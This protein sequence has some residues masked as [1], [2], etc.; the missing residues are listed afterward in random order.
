MKLIVATL[1]ALASCSAPGEQSSAASGSFTLPKEAVL[2]A[3][4]TELNR[5]TADLDHKQPV[6][7]DANGVGWNVH[8]SYNPGLRRYLERREVRRMKA[9]A[10]RMWQEV[11]R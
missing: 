3:H 2:R 9:A 5:W 7:E 10:W 4:L 8:A 1:G 11:Q 6:F